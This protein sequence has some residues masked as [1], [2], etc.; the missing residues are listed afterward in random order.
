MRL[1]HGRALTVAAV[2][3]AGWPAAAAG[4]TQFCS[5][6]YHVEQS[7]PTAGPEQT[8]WKL[9]WQVVDGNNLI[10]TGAWF[11]PSPAGSW[12]KLIYDAR[13]AELFVPYH[14]G[15]PRYLDV[16]Y[17]FSSYPMSA[18]DCP[19]PTGAILGT[20]Q[21]VCKQVRD[22]GLAWKHD[23]QKRRGEELVLWS[24]L[25]AANYNY[26]VEWTFR[27]DGLVMGRV[28]ATGQV[29]GSDTHMHGPIWRLDLD[30][31]GACCDAISTVTH[32]ESG[33]NGTDTHVNVTTEGGRSWAAP[34][35]RKFAIHDQSLV[36][37]NNKTSHW[38]LM[39]LVTG[40]PVHQEAFT[41]STAW[42]TRYRWNEKAGSLVHTYANAENVLNKDVVLWY[43]AGLHHMVRDED[44]AMTHLMWTGF[45]LMP[46]NLF[47]STPLYP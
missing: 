40:T 47:G 26:I 22:R 4:Q 45:M 44:S 42:I 20:D 23:N 27:D 25:A 7:F 9:C 24:V 11:R 21:E 8:R 41:K 32:T 39:P 13:V 12:I 14:A 37:T 43:Y 35:F 31:N 34:W 10:I 38:Q 2:I 6:P 16:G 29:A 1:D 19:A 33:P 46:F 5:A 28:G 3:C 17:N 30:L 36:N 15:S 18:G